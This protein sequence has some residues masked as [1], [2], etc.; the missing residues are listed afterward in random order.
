MQTNK[1]SRID[2]NLRVTYNSWVVSLLRRKNAANPRHAYLVVEGINQFNLGV[3]YRYDLFEDQQD[4]QKAFINIDSKMNIALT[5]MDEAV[6][7]AVRLSP[8]NDKLYYLSWQVTRDQAEQLH[9]NILVDKQ[10]DIEYVILGD[11]SISASRTGHSCFTWAR[12]KLHQ[13]NDSSIQVKENILDY[14]VANPQLYLPKE[15]TSGKCL[16]Q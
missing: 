1:I 5:D 3:L 8:E 2:N 16:M 7:L 13:L 14:I 10:S 4:K 9:H 6:E 12:E 15:G 11:K